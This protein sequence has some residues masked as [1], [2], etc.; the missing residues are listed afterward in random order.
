MD[1]LHKDIKKYAILSVI[2]TAFFP[3]GA[4]MLGVGLSMKTPG[5]WG[6]GIGFLVLGFYGAP[7]CWTVVFAPTKALEKVVNAVHNQHLY[8]VNEIAAQLGCRERTVRDQLDICFRRGYLPQYKR[9]GDH[10]EANFNRDI[11]SAVHAAECPNC[12]A[13]YTF[14][15]DDPRCPYCGSPVPAKPDNR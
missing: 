8:T 1:K 7:S 9:N 10:I 4:I 11:L 12:G 6:T 2:F 5:L 15:P 14:A 13:K 3:I